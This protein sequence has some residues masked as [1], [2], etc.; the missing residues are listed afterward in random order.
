MSYRHDTDFLLDRAVETHRSWC[1]RNGV[2]FDQP[3][4]VDFDGDQVVLSNIRDEI[5][6]YEIVRRDK[7]ETLRRVEPSAG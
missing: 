7:T 1:R 4:S 3:G 6:R 5:A 2:I